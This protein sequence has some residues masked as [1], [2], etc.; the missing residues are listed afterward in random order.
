MCVFSPF[1]SLARNWEI[2]SFFFVL[3]SFIVCLGELGAQGFTKWKKKLLWKLIAEGWV[4]GRVQMPDEDLIEL[5]FRLYDGSDIGP[6][7]YLPASTVAMLKERIVAEWPKGQR[8]QIWFTTTSVLVLFW[9]LYL[10]VICISNMVWMN[11]KWDLLDD[12]TWSCVPS[13]FLMLVYWRFE[14]ITLKSSWLFS[15]KYVFLLSSILTMHTILPSSSCGCCCIKVSFIYGKLLNSLLRLANW[16][17]ICVNKSWFLVHWASDRNVI[18]ERNVILSY[19]F[20]IY[21]LIHKN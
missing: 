20:R 16:R 11:F 2:D 4:G 14:V 13:D 5:K 12:M 1:Y 19:T 3:N 8:V 18:L 15:Y 21:I 17:V 9:V 6:F 10:L 7:R